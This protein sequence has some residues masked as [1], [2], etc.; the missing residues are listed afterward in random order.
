V[1]HRA[2]DVAGVLAA[3]GTGRAG[4]ERRAMVEAVLDDGQRLA[5]LN[6]VYVGDA[7][8][9][10]ARYRLRVPGGPATGERQSS[11][12]VVVA[13]GT[14]AT[15]WC[16]SLVVGRR[17]APALP[18]PTSPELAGFV[19]EAW[20]S[21]TTGVDLTEG[22]LAAGGHLRVVVESDRLVVFGDGLE[23]DRLVAGW[24]QEVT[25]GLAA[26]QLAL[27][28][29]SAPAVSAPPSRRAPRRTSPARS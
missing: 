6:E 13:T 3:V 19:R 26:R 23:A 1:R 18:R 4:V 16:A 12:G 15:G 22:L 8:H 25:V 9:Q 27:V 29:A 21:P 28:T 20:P 14:G 7:G 17:A 24:G 2:A 11:S 5:A 10:S